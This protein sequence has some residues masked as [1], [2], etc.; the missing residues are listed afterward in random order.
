M[1]FFVPFACVRF[2][3]QFG[4]SVKYPALCRGE[5]GACGEFE[6]PEMKHLVLTFLG[7]SPCWKLLGLPG[8]VF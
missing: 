4:F 1:T 8:H 3:P 7:S 6:A 5:A 2:R